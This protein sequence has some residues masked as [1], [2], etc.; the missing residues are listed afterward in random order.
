MR[1]EK[2]LLLDEIQEQIEQ[3][4]SFVL[5]RYSKLPANAVHKL[6]GEVRQKAGGNVKVVKKRILRKAAANLGI[7]FD[8]FDTEGHICVVLAGNDPVETTKMLSQFGKDH[9]NA[10]TIVGGRIEGVV[11]SAEKMD[12][13]AKL[14]SKKELQAQLVSILEAPLSQ[15]VSTIESLLVN[16]VCCIENQA[17]K[18]S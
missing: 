6:R 16:V 17:K 8:H 14:P 2:Q 12:Q 11:Y 5:V 1:K 10:T 9:E 4:D 7:T 13:L 15:T 3:Y 18:I